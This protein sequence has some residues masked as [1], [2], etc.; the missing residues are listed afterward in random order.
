MSP[1]WTLYRVIAEEVELWQADEE[2]K[3]IRLMYNL[4]ENKWGKKTVMV[5]VGII[6]YQAALYSSMVLNADHDASAILFASLWFLIMFSTRKP[7]KQ[8]V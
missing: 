2:R 6:S 4:E 3:H 7:S 1:S 8:I 5:L